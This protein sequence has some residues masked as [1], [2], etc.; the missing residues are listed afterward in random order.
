VP[1]EDEV[2]A[3][4]DVVPQRYLAALWLGAGQGCRLGEALGM[5][6]GDRCIDSGRGQLHIIQQLRYAPQEYGGFYLSEPKAGSSGTIDLAPMVDEALAE[7]VRLFPPTS[8]ELI[9]ITSGEPVY[10]A[11]TVAVHNHTW[12]PV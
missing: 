5:E 6:D 11:G 3:L 4:L 10:L 8:V 2:L 9:D 1:N 7:H 12:Q